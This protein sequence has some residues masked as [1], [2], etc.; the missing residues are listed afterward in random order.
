MKVSKRFIDRA[1]PAVRRY[2]KILDSAKRRDVNESDTSVIVN[3][4]LTDVLGYDKYSDITTEFAVRST[5]CDLAIKCD[6]RLQYLIEVKPVGSD[7]KELYLRQAI[8]YGARE[9]IEWVILTNGIAWQAHRIRFEQPVTHDLVFEVN[10]LDENAK[11]NEMLEKFY[12]ISREAGTCTAL[13]HYWQRQE[14][15]SRYVIAQLLLED[16]TLTALRRNLRSLFKGLNISTA[17]IHDVLETEVIKRDALEGD[18]AESAAKSMRRASRKRAR[19]SE[20]KVVPIKTASTHAA[21]T[22]AS[23]QPALTAPPNR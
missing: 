2:Q 17:D 13:E 4:M 3:D 5:F 14:A 23:E 7:L 20:E 12:L 9:G 21:M 19:N 16:K 6:G 22:N 10:L 15:T 8:E 1:R 18:R 11:T